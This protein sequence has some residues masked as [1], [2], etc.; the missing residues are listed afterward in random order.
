M[1]R[2]EGTPDSED[3]PTEYGGGDGS[4]SRYPDGGSTD[5]SAG[6]RARVMRQRMARP[7]VNND[8][9]ASLPVYSGDEPESED[10]ARQRADLEARTNRYNREV[11]FDD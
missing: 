2:L 4:L 10:I 11:E 7:L 1:A 3:T 9:V 8:P 5:L 6:D